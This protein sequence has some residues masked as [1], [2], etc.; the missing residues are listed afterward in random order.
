MYNHVAVLVPP[1]ALI[2]FVSFDNNR[3]LKDDS[4]KSLLTSSNRVTENTSNG[5]ATSNTS[6][7]SKT[8]I[9][10][11]LVL[12]IPSSILDTLMI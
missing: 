4:V 2:G 9:P 8:K 5:P 1:I 11:V 6:T 3:I 12:A 7:S 10:T